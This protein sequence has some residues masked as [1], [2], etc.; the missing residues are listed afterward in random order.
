MS[1]F[2]LQARVISVIITSISHRRM[3]SSLIYSKKLTVYYWI[4]YYFQFTIDCLLEAG[5]KELETSSAT[6]VTPGQLVSV[7]SQIAQLH[8]P[9]A[10]GCF[11][12]LSLLLFCTYSVSHG[13]SPCV[14]DRLYIPIS[15]TNHLA[16]KQY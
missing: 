14:P 10:K 1:Y 12:S 4:A 16:H 8:L 2:I 3:E 6:R 11:T 15:Q 7:P 5:Y 13:S 9:S